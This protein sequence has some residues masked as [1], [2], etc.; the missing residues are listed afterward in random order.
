MSNSIKRLAPRVKTTQHLV[1]MD[2]PYAP[3]GADDKVD[4]TRISVKG[5]DQQGT[6]HTLLCTPECFRQARGVD[7][8]GEQRTMPMHLGRMDQIRFLVRLNEEG[9]AF[10]IDRYLEGERS[11]LEKQNDVAGFQVRIGSDP[12]GIL[13]MIAAPHN[14]DPADQR[15]I[16]NALS[17]LET[18]SIGDKVGGRIV[19]SINGDVIELTPAGSTQGGSGLADL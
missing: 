9:K 3:L 10:R 1:Y 12:N 6:H 18:I 8:N 2:V 7:A 16:L 17:L 4:A 13:T 5:T 14:T 15:A 19:N 11:M